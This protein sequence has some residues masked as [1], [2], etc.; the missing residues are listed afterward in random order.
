[1]SKS[2]QKLPFRS[3]FD[4]FFQISFPLTGTPQNNRWDK[5]WTNLGFR[6]VLKAVRGKRVRK[7]SGP[8]L[9]DFWENPGIRALYRI[10]N[11]CLV[12]NS[13]RRIKGQHDLSV[14]SSLRPQNRAAAATCGHGRCELPAIWRVTQKSLAASDFVCGRRSEK[15]CNFCSGMVASPL[16]ATVVTAI[17][18]CDFCAAKNTMREENLP[19]RG[20]PR[21]PP[22]TSEGFPLP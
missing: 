22:K 9:I 21:G 4:K 15:P 10:P 2:V 1:M 12:C 3:N 14:P 13:L 5:F 19:L 7:A 18:R 8:S 16:A 20:S 11:I 6:A 17:L